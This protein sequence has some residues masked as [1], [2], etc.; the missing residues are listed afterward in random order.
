[1]QPLPPP[2]TTQITLNC[3]GRLLSL[4]QPRVM[5]I[6]NITP[7]SFSDGG[8]YPSV[9]S[10][11]DHAGQLLADGAAIIDVGG[12]STRPGATDVSQTEEL[13]RV[14][15]VAEA[16][17]GAFPE[18]LFSIDTFRSQVALEALRLGFHLV[19]DIS[20]G[21]FEPDILQV[22]ATHRAPFILMHSRGEGIS[23]LHTDTGYNDILEDVWQYFVRQINRAHSV[24]LYDLILDPG[25]GFSKEVADNYAILRRLDRFLQLGYPILAGLS[26]KRLLTHPLHL[27]ANQVASPLAA[28]HFQALQAGVRILRV[29]EVAPALQVVALWQTWHHGAL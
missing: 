2:L 1:M 18:A 27:S 8:C 12:V 19:N 5:G 6:L 7:D 24:G 21:R 22:A 16:L 3:R 15:P 4:E 9:Q 25:F 26:R 23:T 29:H 20:G 10:A 28:L 13:D 17:V 14:L 11:V